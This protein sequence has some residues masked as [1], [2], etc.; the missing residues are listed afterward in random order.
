M[1]GYKFSSIDW[2]KEREQYL[3]LILK[4]KLSKDKLRG[5]IDSLDGLLTHTPKGIKDLFPEE[6]EQAIAWLKKARSEVTYDYRDSE[7]TIKHLEE[8]FSRLDAEVNRGSHLLNTLLTN[9]QHKAHNV[10]HELVS[11][12]VRLETSYFTNQE[13]L[14]RWFGEDTSDEYRTAVK[15]ATQLMG[16]RRLQDAL[17]HLEITEHSL[18]KRIDDAQHLDGKQEKRLYLLKSLRQVCTEMGFQESEP[19]YTD[20]SD[21]K[22]EII[23]E[24]DTVDQGRIR[25]FL[26]LDGI[27][28]HS[29]ILDE[30]CF[31]EFDKLSSYLDNEYGVKTRFRPENEKP[32]ERLIHKGEL[33]FPEDGQREQS[34]MWR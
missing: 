28:S 1:S 5:I 24:V 8:Q 18:S 15:T 29:D 25:F 20:R 21:R 30:R 6:I 34:F 7:V 14:E 4:I 13:L 32:D 26:T 17:T 10:E 33:D 22:S 16:E 12:V 3:D 9:L 27:R 23:Y 11:K 19:F 31:N 2:E